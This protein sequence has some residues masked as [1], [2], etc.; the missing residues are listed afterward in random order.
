MDLGWGRGKV[1][2]IMLNYIQESWVVRSKVD[3]FNLKQSSRLVKEEKY[4]SGSYNY[5]LSVCFMAVFNY[6]IKAY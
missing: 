5:L 4:A 1:W 2:K 6:F 3:K